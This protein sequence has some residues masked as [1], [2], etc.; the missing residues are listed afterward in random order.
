MPYVCSTTAYRY[1]LI[2]TDLF[3]SCSL[4]MDFPYHLAKI[5]FSFFD[6]NV[7]S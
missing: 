6:Y 2:D 5:P 7:G 1:M 4:S 3:G